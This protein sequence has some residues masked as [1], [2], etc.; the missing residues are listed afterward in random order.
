VTHGANIYLFRKKTIFG[1]PGVDVMMKRWKEYTDTNANDTSSILVF[2]CGGPIICGFSYTGDS[3]EESQKYIQRWKDIAPA[4]I[5]TFKRTPYSH[6]PDSL[7]KSAEK[8]QTTGYYYESATIMG[9][10]PDEC[11]QVLL[12][13]SAEPFIPNRDSIFTVFQV[14]GALSQV[15][16]S[17]TPF[18]QRNAKY[19][20][21]A[22]GKWT[23]ESPIMRAKVKKWV[24]DI[25]AAIKPWAIGSYNTLGEAKAAVDAVQDDNNND[26]F[27]P[28]EIHYG[29]NLDRLR[30][31]KTKYDPFNMLRLNKNIRPSNWTLPP[32]T[33]KK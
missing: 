16:P 10:L 12:K 2:T 19:W 14:G 27:P 11:I 15:D 31:V 24:N 3:A 7:Q 18:Y 4:T 1:F 8:N 33:L 23:K 17:S 21:I 30:K 5:S 22:L 9:S 13:Y 6:T 26:P 29:T 20:I 32:D 28:S 25:T